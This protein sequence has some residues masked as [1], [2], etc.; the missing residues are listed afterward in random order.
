MRLGYRYMVCQLTER[1]GLAPCQS[2][3]SQHTNGLEITAHASLLGLADGLLEGKAGRRE[4]E[5]QSCECIS[6]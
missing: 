5:S 4:G 3:S 2:S 6:A 1:S